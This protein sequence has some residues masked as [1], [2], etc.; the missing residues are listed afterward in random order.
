MTA[1]R[2]LVQLQRLWQRESKPRHG[3]FA[4]KVCSK[5]RSVCSRLND[6]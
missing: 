4:G 2:L 6:S 1:K 5:L 3:G